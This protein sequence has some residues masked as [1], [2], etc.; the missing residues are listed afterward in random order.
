M[1][2]KIPRQGVNLLDAVLLLDG[3]HLLDHLNRGERNYRSR[4]LRIS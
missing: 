1:Y 3:G 2:H 4:L